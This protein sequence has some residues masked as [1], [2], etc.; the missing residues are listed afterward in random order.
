MMQY[1]CP[2]FLKLGYPE[3]LDHYADS[4]ITNPFVDEVIGV[5]IFCT[6]QLHNSH[7]RQGESPYS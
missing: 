4:L 3:P 6:P 1:E 5:Q 7:L 2:L